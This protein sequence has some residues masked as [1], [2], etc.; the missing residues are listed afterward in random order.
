MKNH[1]FAPSKTL[2]QT[3]GFLVLFSRYPS[4]SQ[5]IPPLYQKER[6]SSFFFG[7]QQP[8]CSQGYSN[9]KTTRPFNGSFKALNELWNSTV[10]SNRLVRPC[11]PLV[12]RELPLEP[13]TDPPIT[14]LFKDSLGYFF[15]NSSSESPRERHHETPMHRLF[16]IYLISAIQGSLISLLNHPTN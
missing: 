13:P 12:G 8:G 9:A 10:E 5:G 4:R 16:T 15:R 14:R 11:E 7:N 6:K 3:N 2:A 1:H